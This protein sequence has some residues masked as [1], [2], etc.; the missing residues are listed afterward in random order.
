MGNLTRATIMV[1]DNGATL[2]LCARSLG[3]P[4][5]SPLLRV[6]KKRRKTKTGLRTCAMQW[7]VRYST[8]E[9]RGGRGDD[10]LPHITQLHLHPLRKR[11][12]LTN[13][14]TVTIKLKNERNDRK[15]NKRQ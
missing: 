7:V 15:K 14:A 10:A 9:R 1:Q 8:R 2:A 6:Q 5:W 12:P 11:M 13:H 3:R 4:H